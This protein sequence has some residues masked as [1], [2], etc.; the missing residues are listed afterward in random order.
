MRTTPSTAASHHA[1]DPRVIPA[2]KV[3]WV[4]MTLFRSIRVLASL[5]SALHARL[6]RNL[7]PATC[8]KTG[9]AHPQHSCDG[10]GSRAQHRRRGSSSPRTA[11]AARI[12]PLAPAA[13]VTIS[14]ITL[15]SLVTTPATDAQG[16]A[17]SRR[18][19]C[20]SCWTSG[21]R[22]ELLERPPVHGGCELRF[23]T[24]GFREERAGEPHPGG[25]GHCRLAQRPSQF[26]LGD[27]PPATV[28]PGGLEVEL[29]GVLVVPRPHLDP[30]NAA[31]VLREVAEGVD[32]GVAVRVLGRNRS[33]LLVVLHI[34]IF[35]V[36]PSGLARDY[37]RYLAP[38]ERDVYRG[39]AR[40]RLDVDPAVSPR[41]VSAA[42][43]P[44]TSRNG[45]ASWSRAPRS[46][47]MRRR[48]T[49]NPTST[50]SGSGRCAP[51]GVRGYP[52]IHVYLCRGAS[53][54][55]RDAGGP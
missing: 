14:S 49:A 50:C 30:R 45:G 48:P 40:E 35:D 44:C 2:A 16:N 37:A 38:R 15:A 27:H 11:A 6:A 10:L 42:S 13:I 21:V 52:A 36:T 41:S 47:R 55:P 8:A 32:D 53:L 24:R 54:L 28:E 29:V 4:T 12:R 23:R 5:R 9:S 51:T 39:D 34:V 17:S 22:R 33:E 20:S 18:F 31:R 3:H 43:A 26:G 46:R 25:A 19:T 1:W 7:R